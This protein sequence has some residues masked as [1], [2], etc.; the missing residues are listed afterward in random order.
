MDPNLNDLLAETARLHRHLCP[1]QVLGVRMGLQAGA[2]LGLAVPQADK[3]LL[4]IVEMDGCFA[5]GVSTAV[6]CWVGRRT[7]RVED[8]GKTAASF[9][10]TWT[11]LGVRISPRDGIRVAARDYAPETRHSWQAQ[12]WGYQRMP[13]AELLR[14]EAISLKRPIQE[15]LGR[16]G[17]RTV[18]DHCGEE[19]LN[20]REIVRGEETLCQ[21]CAGAAYYTASAARSFGAASVP[22]DAAS[23]STHAGDQGVEAQLANHASASATRWTTRESI[24]S[25]VRGSLC[26]RPP[27]ARTR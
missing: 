15:I 24:P 26:M 1:R 9:V 19:I 17:V 5:D 8:F 14:W 4:T 10:D 20:C 11:G 18:C 7:L 16:P 21:G 12:L 25:F 6:N 13:A 23:T 2:L 3:R 22:E 27:S